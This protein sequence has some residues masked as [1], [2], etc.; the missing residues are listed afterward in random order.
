MDLVSEIKE[1][2]MSTGPVLMLYKGHQQFISF[3]DMAGP[4]DQIVKGLDSQITLGLRVMKVVGW[5]IRDQ[6]PKWVVANS[7]GGAWGDNGYASITMASGFI[8][9]FYAFTNLSGTV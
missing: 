9:G 7:W 5:S 4:Q 1:S 3:L 2:L 6:T 8:E